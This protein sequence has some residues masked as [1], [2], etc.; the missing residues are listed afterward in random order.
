MSKADLVI[1]LPHIGKG[2]LVH[3]QLGAVLEARGVDDEVVVQL[4]V[5]EVG[6]YNDF[7]L[8]EELPDELHPNLVSLLRCE[9]VL[10]AEGLDILIEQDVILPLCDVLFLLGFVERL[11]CKKGFQ[12]HFRH[13][14]MSADKLHPFIQ[15][16]FVRTHTVF[17]QPFQRRG[18]LLAFGYILNDSY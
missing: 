10:R 7:V 2:M 17:Q 9:L 1:E 12:C 11:R 4:I 14:V 6:G 3:V 8:R 5:V 16:C 18:C 13:T 15:I